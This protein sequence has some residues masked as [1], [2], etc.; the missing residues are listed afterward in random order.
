[1][2]VFIT[3][4]TGLIGSAL[5]D[6]LVSRG[7][8]VTVLTRN[9][10]RAKQKLGDKVGICTDLDSLKS[11]DG[12]EAVINLA[13][14]P[15]IGKRWSKKQKEKLCESRWN[16]TSRLAG[17]IR[18]SRQPPEVFISGSAIG[19]Y[20]AGD[21]RVLTERST[22]RDGFIHRLCARWEQLALDAQSGQTRICVL[23]TG[24]VLSDKGGMLPMML[25]P[26]RLGLGATMGSGNQYLSWVHIRDMVNG[27]VFLLDN[28][29]AQGTFNMTS[30]HAVTNRTF[31]KTLSSVLSR[32]CLFRIPAFLLK[33]I[34][35][36][37]ATMITEGQ[38][39][40]PRHL[41]TINFSFAFEDLT[42]A[43]RD[44]LKQQ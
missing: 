28:P 32:P 13:G 7:D 38:R 22:H 17:L 15:I 39:V 24:I 20:G 5:I 27:I 44:L 21:D 41:Q 35:G 29:E 2:R 26:F 9:N 34:M 19:Y 40:A 25:L 16:T 42:L 10:T 3:G 43:F 33:L 23:R 30:P 6:E 37:M 18:E 31:S 36:E 11:L 1:M 14:E 12:Y 4:G 8:S